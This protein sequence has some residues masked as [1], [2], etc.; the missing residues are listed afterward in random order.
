M[1]SDNYYMVVANAIATASKDESTKLGAVIVGKGGEIRST[2][3]NSFPR[4]IDDDVSERQERPLK[5]KWF[6]HAEANAIANAARCGVAIEGCRI[7]CQWLPCPTCAQLII[8][9]GITGIVVDSFTVPERWQGDMRISV[10][11]LGEAG[12]DMRLVG[13]LGPPVAHILRQFDG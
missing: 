8:G 10:T 11:M 3:Y 6:C 4:G 12:I 7:Y 2:G 9:A 5:Y 1:P 13:A